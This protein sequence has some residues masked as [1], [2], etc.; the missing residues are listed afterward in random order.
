[1]TASIKTVDIIVIGCGPGGA[2]AARVAAANGFS[3]VV[4]EKKDLS[5]G[6]RYKACGGALAWDLVDGTHLPEDRIDRVIEELEIHHV[7]GEQYTKKGKGAVVWRSVFDLY[8]MELAQEEGAVVCDQEPLIRIKQVDQVSGVNGEVQYEIRT[9]KHTYLA[10]FV[11]CA[12]GM[13]SRTLRQ[14]NWPDFAKN[15]VILT[16]TNE[17]KT[18]KAAIKN[19]LGVDKI[20]LF[21][22]VKNLI[23]VGYAWLFPKAEHITTGWGNL[24]I[25]GAVVFV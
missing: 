15:D 20:H 7:D 1:M 8:L 14:L 9:T 21:F 19:T 12:D 10:R 17:M 3:T 5:N 25:L 2:G 6:G 22:G 11:I 4:V 16:L 13:P 24:K 23:P 18:S